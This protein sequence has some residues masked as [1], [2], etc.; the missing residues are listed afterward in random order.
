MRNT[1]VSLDYTPSWAINHIYDTSGH[2]SLPTAQLYSYFFS[3]RTPLAWS[4]RY[5]PSYLQLSARLFTH[6]DLVPSCENLQGT[7][8]YN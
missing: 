3:P 5:T 8:R 7:V 4:L 2:L 1:G 6:P